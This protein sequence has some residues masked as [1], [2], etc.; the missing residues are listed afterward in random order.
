MQMVTHTGGCHCGRVSFEVIAPSRLTVSNCNCSICTKS[1]YRHLLVSAD[2]F[3]LL[4]GQDALTTYSFNTR[5]AKHLF[6]STCGIKAFY[7][8]RSNPNGFSV[9]ANCIDSDTIEELTVRDTDGRNWEAT[10]AKGVWADG[11]K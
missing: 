4:S 11:S 10:H 5:T 9:N 2:R 8:P 3:K 7:V 6:C 1:G